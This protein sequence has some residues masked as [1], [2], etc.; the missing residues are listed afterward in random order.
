MNF[1]ASASRQTNFDAEGSKNTH[2]PSHSL[3]TIDQESR[4]ATQA[5]VAG[6]ELNMKK[7][8]K[9]YSYPSGQ[10][11][12]RTEIQTYNHTSHQTS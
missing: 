12:R 7:L 11:T 6:E 3:L 1:A 10:R 5:I 8:S 4:L 2:L 9:S